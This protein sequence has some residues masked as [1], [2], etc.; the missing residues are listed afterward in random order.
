ML[1]CKKMNILYLNNQMKTYVSQKTKINYV[2]NNYKEVIFPRRILVQV[3]TIL[4]AEM[5]THNGRERDGLQLQNLL[6]LNLH[7]KLHNFNF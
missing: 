2:Y 1:Y 7:L 3:P 5:M 4:G 6:K